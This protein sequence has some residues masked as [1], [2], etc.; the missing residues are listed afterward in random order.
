MGSVSMRAPP[1]PPR[2]G[3][4]AEAGGDPSW[5]PRRQGTPDHSQPAVLIVGARDALLTPLTEALN[6]HGVF[7]ESTGLADVMQA[8]IAGAPDLILLADTA[9]EDRGTEVIG[10]LATSPLSSVIPIAILDDDTGLEARLQAFRHGAAALVRRSAS[11][12]AIATEVTRLLHEIPERSTLG[13]GDI[14]EVTLEELVSTLAHEL[15][16]GILSVRTKG[17]EGEDPVRLVLGGGRPVSAIIDEFVQR[18]GTHVLSAEPL[19]YEF[20]ERAAG[21]VQLFGSDSIPPPSAEAKVDG[22]R[23]LLA[24]DDTGRADAVAQELR[25]YG[26]TVVVTDLQPSE[27]RFLRLRELDPMLLVIG[28]TQISGDGY[29]L[30]QRL[31]GDL[32]LRWA[33]LLVVD[34]GEIWPE[35]A[36]APEIQRLL[37]AIHALGEP[38]RLISQRVE[39]APVVELRL[40]A[41]GPARLLRSLATVGRSLR[42]TVHHSR[43]LVRIDVSDGL[44][45]GAKADTLS[46]SEDTVAGAAALS[47]LM[48][49]GSG[50]VR[51]EHVNQPAVANLMATPDVA[52]NMA[53]AEAP[54]IAPSLPAPMLDAESAGGIGVS[55]WLVAV[56]IV[57]AVLAVAGVVVLVVLLASSPRS[58]AVDSPS[59]APVVPSLA[60]VAPVVQTTATATVI[61]APSASASSPPAIDPEKICQEI[62]AQFAGGGIG[63]EL[64]NASRAMMQGD[65]KAA[66][67][68]YCVATDRYPE[69]TAALTGLVRLLMLDGEPNVALHYAEKLAKLDPESP[70]YRALVGDAQAMLG[71]EDEA[72]RAFCQ[73]AGV[74]PNKT[75]AVRVVERRYRAVAYR[76]L[77]EKRYGEGVRYFRRAVTLNPESVEAMLGLSRALLLTGEKQASLEWARK[78]EKLAPGNVQVLV[79][80]GD[81]LARSGDRVG[82]VRAWKKGLS[83]EPGNAEARFRMLQVQREQ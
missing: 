81:A 32:R 12:D 53:N 26:A 76:A 45:V 71:N 21:T 13:L 10:R 22:I 64:K 17:Q 8:V 20:D 11:V 39:Q 59:A 5:H 38:E 31:R 67:R 74:D 28:E 48:V 79:M 25:H 57:A 35:Q 29:F 61:A 14:G 43:A 70:R 73:A 33:S 19:E 75:E 62:V 80:L 49:M 36:G 68:W 41:T 2:D 66:R 82:A 47:A 24:D 46:G 18:M 1:A 56:G 23:V 34:W 3:P 44:I 30:V 77:K 52:L 16:S 72:R 78:A 15:R 58:P 63:S 6:R 7:V 83:I 37:G 42:T 54:P 55:P 50:R 4:G 65:L 40:E 9:A 27:Q 51:V 69:D 60:P